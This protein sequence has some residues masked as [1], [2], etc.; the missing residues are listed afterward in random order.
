M[1]APNGAR[2]G[3]SDHPA[4]PVTLPEIIDTARA[5]HEAGA[6][7]LHL[8][9]RDDDGAHSL[10]AGRYREA[11]SELKAQ[12][13]GM[14][15][16]ITTEAA[17]VFDVAA[18][19]ACLRDVQP[20]WASISIREMARDPDVAWRVYDLCAEQGTEVQHILYDTDDATL[21]RDWQERG[22]IRSNQTSTIF[23]LGRYTTTRHASPADIAPFRAALPGAA[24]WMVCAFG[25]QEHACLVAAA[26]QAGNLRV[27]FE[28]SFTAADGAVHTDNAASVTIL[29]TLL[30]RSAVVEREPLRPQPSVKPGD[31]H[32][33]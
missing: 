33:I 9:V 12:V 5:C 24:N 11:L 17:G 2:R 19:R 15:T 13:P 22:I 8:H 20:E 23:V 16:Q 14:R 7:A 26:E 18:Q 10:D 25:P 29:C 32:S 1:V 21:L 30:K 28:N 3:K 31:R 6:D 27:G 4:L